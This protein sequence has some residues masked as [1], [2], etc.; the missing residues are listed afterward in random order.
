MALKEKFKVALIIG[1]IRRQR[2]GIHVARWLERTLVADGFQV[3]V[4][5]PQAEPLPLVG[6]RYKDFEPGQAPALLEK[7]HQLFVGA[8]GFVFVSPEYNHSTSGVI[9]NVLD[10]FGRIEFGYKPALLTTY[11]DGPFGGVRSM[12][13]L[14][15]I[16]V[17]LGMTPLTK[18]ISISAVD[19]VFGPDDVLVEAVKARYEK[20]AAEAIAQ[21][22]W[23]LEAF[24]TQRKKGLPT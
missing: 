7:L 21:F 22:R 3:T 15:Q 14:R 16:V 19:T 2:Q 10:T 20:Q 18:P 17:E 5:D 13:Y 8:D 11:S 23:Y 12:E 6:D 1:S 4:F 9:K 24:Q